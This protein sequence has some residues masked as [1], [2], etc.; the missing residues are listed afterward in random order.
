MSTTLT[1]RTHCATARLGSYL[2]ALAL[3]IFFQTP[4]LG[5][6]NEEE[7]FS[8]CLRLRNDGMFKVAAGQWE[9]FIDT[10]P[11]SPRVPDALLHG[12]ACYL[13]AGAPEDAARLLG[14]Y[15]DRFKDHAGACR[16][17]FDLAQLRRETGAYQEAFAH[18]LSLVS[19]YPDCDLRNEALLGQA[20]CLYAL[21]NFRG[22]EDLA[23]IVIAAVEDERLAT[24]AYY[25]LGIAEAGQDRLVE[26]LRTFSEL[27][28][29]Y[30]RH[31][32]AA[33][34]L[35]KAAS[36]QVGRD[37]LKGAEIAYRTVMEDFD[38]PS[39]EASATIE[40]A[41]LLAGTD[42]HEQSASL[43]EDFAEK[44]REHPRR[45]E[46]LLEGARSFEHLQ[47]DKDALGLARRYL[48]DYPE[49][50]RRNEARLLAARVLFRQEKLEESTA[51]IAAIDVESKEAST[52]LRLQG[53]IHLA[54]NEPRRALVYFEEYLS[55]IDSE[56]EKTECLMLMAETYVL[57]LGDT[58]S[59]LGVLERIQRTFPGSHAELRST[60]R[61]AELAELS[62]RWALAA[63]AYRRLSV[64][65]G[66]PWRPY[67]R[68]I[69]IERHMVR[70]VA[71]A[72]ETLAEWARNRDGTGS[73]EDDELSLSD[74]YFERLRD[75][76]TALLLYERHLRAAGDPDSEIDRS[77]SV[78]RAHF[79]IGRCAEA[80]ADRAAL[81]HRPEKEIQGHLARAREELTFTISRGG[82]TELAAEAAFLLGK[83]DSDPSREDPARMNRRYAR[84]SI[85]RYPRSRYRPWFHLWLSRSLA[86]EASADSLKLSVRH[87]DLGLTVSIVSGEV[88]WRLH[89]SKGRALRLLG[90]AEDA[91]RALA[92]AADLCP[93]DHPDFAVILY[94]AA[95]ARAMFEAHARA[96][97]GFEEV[98]TSWPRRSVGERAVLR[99]GDLYFEEGQFDSSATWY[100]RFLEL[101]PSSALEADAVFRHALA[102]E[103]RGRYRDALPIWQRYLDEYDTA[104]QSLEAY[105]HFALCAGRVESFEIALDA[106]DHYYSN[107][108]EAASDEMISLYCLAAQRTGSP[109]RGLSFLSRFGGTQE[110]GYPTR[111]VSLYWRTKLL[112]S[113]G[114]TVLG[115]QTR[116]L[117]EERYSKLIEER[118][119]LLLAEALVAEGEDG[120]VLLERCI[121]LFP[122]T[123]AGREAMY[124]RGLD[125]L[126][127]K[128][129]AEAVTVLEEF[130]TGE[131]HPLLGV[132]YYQ[133]GRAYFAERR[134]E[135]AAATF[136]MCR[137]A[138]GLDSA[139]IY[140]AR[141]G[142]GISY[143]ELGAWARASTVWKELLA[144]NREREV[145][146]D[147]LFRLGHCLMENGK[148]GEA[149]AA[150]KRVLAYAS[151][152]GKARAAYW[153]GA[154]YE[155]MGMLE[156][157][158]TEYLKVSYLYTGEGMWAVTADLKAA[159]V[160]ESMGRAD[161]AKVLYERVI[162]QHGRT[163]QWGT[164]AEEGLTR[165]A[166][167]QQ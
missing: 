100:A 45:P 118:A 53:E 21:G 80:L 70:D 125:R 88:E 91:A 163:S 43:F 141:K 114:E 52:S 75:Y 132:G 1:L 8:F 129:F 65:S 20:E 144:S 164:V 106:L 143:Q 155:S 117:F 48:E 41:F 38:E 98:R 115:R 142:E 64:L 161:Q 157:A 153:T 47:R 58:I 69:R 109:K 6:A 85:S 72:L 28:R 108:E 139:T 26:S 99:I 135:E 97:E 105:R 136:A 127:Q 110:G 156:S 68:S 84:D 19:D 89:W 29:L 152:E 86:T 77:R 126:E 3:V 54:R 111:T 10:Y 73:E 151:R 134:F 150:Y 87:A 112:F 102:L 44:Y 154:C 101:Y 24:R 50:E 12:A 76:D 30:P 40:L 147:L 63:S 92:R 18:F 14:S 4:A 25:V 59:A 130:V 120:S 149:V 119:D 137:T 160:Y 79:S 138:A 55:A 5:Q 133:L 123:N 81:L 66:E 96:R 165:L 122:R 162:E 22:A 57:E 37:D 146:G 23:R 113:A 9:E 46:A 27:S 78:L 83:L 121:E 51:A 11:D 49:G 93:P 36:I 15:L 158:V 107:S 13:E 56:L 7:A 74:V 35:L 166:E 95:D 32:T 167:K 103:R 131:G 128:Q 116:A 60:E 71:G 16:A 34:G 62:G 94:E 42:R 124:R 82:R 39:V 33:L 67:E 90:R 31:P 145:T 2:S 159:R 17:R 61:M 140:A 148:Y 104:S